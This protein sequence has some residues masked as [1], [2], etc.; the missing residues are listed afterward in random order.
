MDFEHEAWWAFV[1]AIP[2]WRKRGAPSVGAMAKAIN[3]NRMFLPSETR[4]IDEALELYL[5]QEQVS[6][7]TPDRSMFRRK[8]FGL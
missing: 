3:H 6:E 5:T 2:L 7:R 1:R 4:R 8:G